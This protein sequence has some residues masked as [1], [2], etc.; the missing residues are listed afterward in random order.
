MNKYKVDILKFP[1]N[2]FTNLSK[3]NNSWLLAATFSIEISVILN[4]QAKWVKGMPLNSVSSQTK[5]VILRDRVKY[6]S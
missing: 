5:E 6:I 4:L 2:L 3:S 1:N